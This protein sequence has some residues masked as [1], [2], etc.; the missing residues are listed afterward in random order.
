MDHQD[1][2]DF[3]SQLK[4][5]GQRIQHVRLDHIIMPTKV[6]FIMVDGSRHE[7][8]F[9]VGMTTLQKLYAYDSLK[10]EFARRGDRRSQAP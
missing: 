4:Q 5:A 9:P 6:E 8:A 1:L 2:A 3:G 7:Y 10:A